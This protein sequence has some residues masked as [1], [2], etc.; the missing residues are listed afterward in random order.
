MFTGLNPS[1][2]LFHPVPFK[3]YRIIKA[4][5]E[6]PWIVAVNIDAMHYAP[7]AKNKEIAKG[8]H[9]VRMQAQN[10]L[11]T[12]TNVLQINISIIEYV[13]VR[14][15]TK[16]RHQLQSKWR[17]PIKVE[18]AKANLFFVLEDINN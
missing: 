15:H 4:L 2:F 5:I 9:L 12:K 6:E 17:G 13:K 16:W 10:V 8:N 18:E 7:E 11:N 14:T 1:T 3:K